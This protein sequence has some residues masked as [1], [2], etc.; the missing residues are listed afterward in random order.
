MKAWPKQ[1]LVKVK[2]RVTWNTVL[3]A[4]EV[5]A[6]GTAPAHIWNRS[7]WNNRW[8]YQ[9]ANVA[10]FE[11]NPCNFSALN[12]LSIWDGPAEL[13]V[14]QSYKANEAKDRGQN[15]LYEALSSY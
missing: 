5:I 14:S 9:L 1:G 10:L 13:T 3:K 6:A 11:D 15:T 8:I 4:V 12:R 2:S 7:Q